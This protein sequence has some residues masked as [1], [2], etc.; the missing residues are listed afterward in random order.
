[1]P[2]PPGSDMGLHPPLCTGPGGA[3]HAFIGPRGY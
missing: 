1:M 2:G 3:V